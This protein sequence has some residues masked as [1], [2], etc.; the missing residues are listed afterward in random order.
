LTYDWSVSMMK[1]IYPGIVFPGDHLYTQDAFMS[2]GRMAFTFNT[3]LDVN[4]QRYIIFDTK[5][6]IVL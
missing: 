6:Y 5:L 1:K 4:S 3:F 2:D